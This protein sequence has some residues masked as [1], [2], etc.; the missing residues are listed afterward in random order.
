MAG[1]WTTQPYEHVTAAGSQARATTETAV[2]LPVAVDSIAAGPV[3]AGMVV[4]RFTDIEGDTVPG[5]PIGVQI[6]NGTVTYNFPPPIPSR[7]PLTTASLPPTPHPN[8]AQPPAP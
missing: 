1:G 2:V 3:P 7:M 6:Q 8:F 5:P 4:S